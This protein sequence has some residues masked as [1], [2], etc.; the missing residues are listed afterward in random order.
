[1]TVA[2]IIYQVSLSEGFLCVMM[3]AGTAAAVRASQ[4]GGTYGLSSNNH[5]YGF[6]DSV[7]KE[8]EEIRTTASAAT[9]TVF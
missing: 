3:C 5:Y 9:L 1:M 4:R 8:L 7:S 6:A 2:V